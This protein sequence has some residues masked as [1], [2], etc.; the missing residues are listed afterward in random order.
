MEIEHKINNNISD[1][2]TL[3]SFTKDPEFQHMWAKMHT[4]WKRRYRKIRPNEICPF[5]NSGLK[6]KKCKCFESYANTPVY[7]INK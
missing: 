6:F 2:E 4:P 7:T 3:K 1:A 5:C